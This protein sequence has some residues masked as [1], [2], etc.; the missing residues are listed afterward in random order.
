MVVSPLFSHKDS[1]NNSDVFVM[2]QEP[3][4]AFNSIDESRAARCWHKLSVAVTDRSD[5]WRT[6]SLATSDSTGPE[7]RTVVLRGADPSRRLLE[8]HT[9]VR[10]SKTRHLAEGRHV[11]WMFYDGS[12]KQQLRCRGAVRL[13]REDAVAQDAW[14][15][16]HSRSRATY[17]QLS[18]PGEPWQENSPVV[19]DSAAF[20]NFL[21][22]DCIIE[23]MDWLQL[24]EN[25]NVRILMNATQSGWTSQRVSP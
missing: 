22:V 11:A 1:A 23:H 12:T 16:L 7:V 9:D 2:T 4:R 24:D 3:D 17:A 18:A 13:H 21:L 19:E 8:F 20:S 25:E 14:N 5:P 6:P 15:Q 10:S